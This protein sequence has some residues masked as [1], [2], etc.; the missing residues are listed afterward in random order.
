MEFILYVTKDA[1]KSICQD[2][3]RGRTLLKY[4]L[5]STFTSFFF[6]FLTIIGFEFLVNQFPACIRNR[7]LVELYIYEHCPHQ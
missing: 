7:I 3:I 5:V 2:E 6:F 4:N 1:Y